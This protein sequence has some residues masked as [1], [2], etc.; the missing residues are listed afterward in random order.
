MTTVSDIV[1]YLYTLAP[2]YMAME[3]DHVGLLCGDRKQE[4]KRILVSLDPS[5]NA[6]K[7]A[8]TLHADVLLTHHPLIFCAPDAITT[9]SS[10]GRCILTLAKNSISAINAHTNLDQAPGGVNDILAAVLG[11]TDTCVIHPEGKDE[12]GRDW[13][14]LRGGVVEPRP[15]EDFLV[16]V[17]D[18]LS[19]PGLR[20][21]SG[22]KN[23]HRAAVGG[24]SCSSELETV[25]AEGYDTFVTADVKYNGF[26]DAA[27][28]G[29]NLID[30]GH[31][32]TENPV[33]TYLYNAF[34][35]KFPDIEVILS[36]TNLDPM[37]FF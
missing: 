26:L 22:G 35:K 17:K 27:D 11:L 1:E 36:K 19:C 23:V 13:G 34:T 29:I 15:L 31:Y 2:R 24:G 32:R 18:K 9:D 12:T 7:E 28:L 33:C 8:V 25:A 3:W 5:E 21:V 10:V 4:V 16:T 14:L 20:Y 6:C 37:K 30:A